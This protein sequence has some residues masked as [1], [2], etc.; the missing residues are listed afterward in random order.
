M[1]LC[2][3]RSIQVRSK[4]VHGAANDDG[5][6]SKKERSPTRRI[7]PCAFTKVSAL[8]IEEKRSNVVADFMDA[9]QELGDGYRVNAKIVVWAEVLEGLVSG[10]TVIRHPANQIDEGVRVKAE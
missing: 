3:E 5:R 2:R 9:P 4:S 10:E 1:R 7:E 6:P 8:G